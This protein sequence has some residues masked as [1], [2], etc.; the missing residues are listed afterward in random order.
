MDIIRSQKPNKAHGWDK[1]SVRMIKYF[2][3]ALVLPL[4]VA[5]LNCLSRVIF[6]DAWKCANVVPLH[7]KNEKNLKENCR[8]ISLLPMFGKILEKVTFD[9]LYSHLVANNLLSLSQCGFRPGDSAISQL[10]SINQTIPSAFDCDPTPEV[11][12]VFL[13][14]SKAFDRVWH[15]CLLY[16]L[17]RC[18]I[19]G[20]LFNLL[21]SFLSNRKKRTVLSGKSSSWGMFL[22]VFHKALS[23]GPCFPLMSTI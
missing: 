10:L 12:S 15:E 4:K 11:P 5:F 8:P 19:S 17:R 6:L 18:C 3:S 14:I 13:D 16:K 22:Q 9:S 1:V 20:N 23:W 21:H 7:K 2:D